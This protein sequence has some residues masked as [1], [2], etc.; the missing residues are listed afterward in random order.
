MECFQAVCPAGIAPITI[1]EDRLNL[2][3]KDAGDRFA[4]HNRGRKYRIIDERPMPFHSDPQRTNQADT[5][6]EVHS[7][8]SLIAIAFFH[9]WQRR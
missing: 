8:A 1:T 7:N 3:I 4:E 5:G 6:W 9:Y 2:A